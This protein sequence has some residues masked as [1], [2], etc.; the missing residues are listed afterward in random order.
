ME[1]EFC[2]DVIAAGSLT[3]LPERAAA[4]AAALA[5]AQVPAG[6]GPAVAGPDAR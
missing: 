6:L 2:A 3:A 1:P 5:A 4:G